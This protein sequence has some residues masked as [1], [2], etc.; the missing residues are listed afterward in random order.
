MS[1]PLATTQKFAVFDRLARMIVELEL[2]PGTRLIEADLAARLNVSKT[3][4]RE[5]LLLLEAENLVENNPYHGATVTWLS[6]EEYRE[7]HFLLDALEVPA[8]PKVVELISQDD[9]A[10]VQKLVERAARA[11]KAKNS[12]LF[13]E[14]TTEIHERLFRVA[15]SRRLT[16]I[17]K[18]LVALAGRRQA[19]VFQHQFA[20]A[21][22]I[23]LEL[24]TARFEG[25]LRRDPDAAAKAMREGHARLYELG[26]QRIDHPAVKPY[27]LQLAAAA[28]IQAIPIKRRRKQ[29]IMFARGAED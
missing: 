5:A 7:V 16:R 13:G 9:L 17:V 18:S 2:P 14:L 29:T 15:R 11:R 4:I 21:W 10:A 1:Q 3:P 25:I 24:I 12:T 22:D 27:V 6:L 20:D 28:D 23:E 26:A 19:R 8:L